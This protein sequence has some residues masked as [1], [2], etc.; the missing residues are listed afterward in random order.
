MDNW[1]ALDYSLNTGSGSGDMFLYVLD[2]VFDPYDG[3]D[4]VTLY[5]LFGQ[6]GVV[7]RQR[8]QQPAFRGEITATRT[9]SKN[10]RS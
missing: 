5:S 8:L 6:Q 3:G 2:S 1:V 4:V 9:D 7:T 10:G